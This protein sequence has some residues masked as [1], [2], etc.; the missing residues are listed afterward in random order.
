M[1]GDRPSVGTNT[2]EQ[3]LQILFPRRLARAA[4]IC[5]TDVTPPRES[6]KGRPPRPPLSPCAPGYRISLYFPWKSKRCRF[7]RPEI[8]LFKRLSARRS[9]LLDD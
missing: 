9:H 6:A 3:P 1:A 4:R 7:S 5:K 2:L 8:R